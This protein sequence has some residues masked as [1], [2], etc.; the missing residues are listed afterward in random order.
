MGG[1]KQ[2][3]K[4]ICRPGTGKILFVAGPKIK[5]NKR[6]RNALKIKINGPAVFVFSFSNCI[7]HRRC[8]CARP[9]RSGGGDR[10]APK[11]VDAEMENIFL[12]LKLMNGQ[13]KMESSNLFVF[14]F[15]IFN[16]CL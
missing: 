9:Q 5:E 1:C 6:K 3:N 11:D 4:K 7:F 13:N 14:H 2:N 15:C 12:S 16:L 10:R 8:A